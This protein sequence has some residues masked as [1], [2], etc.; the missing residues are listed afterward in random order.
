MEE[1]VACVGSA[2]QGPHNERSMEDNMLVIVK[3]HM[4][5]GGGGG[6]VVGGAA[7]VE[8]LPHMNVSSAH[9]L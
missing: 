4:R 6:G 1:S 3:V 8:H 7:D 5:C 9:S 2:S